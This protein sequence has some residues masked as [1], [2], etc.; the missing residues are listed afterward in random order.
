MKLG[1][2]KVFSFLF[3]HSLR[4]MHGVNMFVLTGKVFEVVIISGDHDEAGF[5]ATMK[6]VPWISVPFADISSR[7]S[8]NEYND[9][10][11]F[12]YVALL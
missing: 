1:M 10:I 12:K 7:K 3:Y 6:D 8:V 5:S 11:D 4:F 9:I 2:L